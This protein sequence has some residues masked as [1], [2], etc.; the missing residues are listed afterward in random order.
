MSA[1]EPDQPQLFVR[2]GSSQEQRQ[3]QPLQE[4]YFAL[5]EM[6]F[7]DLL[8][9]AG[10][11]ARL[12]KFYQLDNT[13]DGDW[14]AYFSADETLVMA[15]ILSTRL[16]PLQAPFE[17]WWD[18]AAARSIEQLPMT[19]LARLLDGWI[20][21][22]AG[23]QGRAGR[24]LYALLADVIA[25]LCEDGHG[26]AALLPAPQLG[27]RA[28]WRRPPGASARPTLSGIKSNYYAFVKA[29]EMV[30]Q[31]AAR[32]LPGSL[33]SGEH[34][35]GAA[36]LIAFIRMA[37]RLNAR[38]NRF[39]GQHLDFYYDRILRAPALPAV[40]DHSYLV[41]APC[42]PGASVEIPAGT[43]FLAKPPGGGPE[44]VYLSDTR[45]LVGDASVQ[46]LHTLYFNRDRNVSPET[47]M[48]K[49]GSAPARHAWPSHAWIEHI[50]PPGKQV[51]TDP[52]LLRAVPLMG[53]P[54]N[55]AAAGQARHARLG[56]ALASNV[57]LMREGRRRLSL[58]L[59]FANQDLQWR[60]R[61]LESV[62]RH[63]KQQAG[64]TIDAVEQEDV[65]LRIL[66]S[67]FTMELTGPAGWI[68]LPAYHPSTPAAGGRH[69]AGYTLR[70]ECELAL[71]VPPVVAYTPALHG[72][73]FQVEVP[74]LRLLLNPDGYVYPYGLLRDLKLSAASIEV[75][76]SGCR[77]FSLNNQIGQLSPAA[78]FQPF[79]PVPV[80]GSYLIVGAGEAAGKELRHFHVDLEWG[81]LPADSGG[82]KTY[83]HDY[84]T[85][86]ET[87]DYVA[88]VAVLA[89]GV[90]R[91][92]EDQAPLAALFG[93]DYAR[94]ASRR[95]LKHSRL[96]CDAVLGHIRPGAALPA[97]GAAYSAASRNGY[98]KF[99]LAGPRFAFGHREYPQALA[100]A[101][102]RNLRG[103]GDNF[104][105]G[106]PE[107]PYTPLVA[108]ITTSYEAVAHIALQ[109]GGAAPDGGWNN[110][111]LHLH[112]QGWE[113]A[114]ASAAGGATLI[115]SYTELGYLHIGLSASELDTT[116]TLFFH[117][118]DDS[119][120]E[121]PAPVRWSYLRGNQWL[122]LPQRNI[123]SDS[124]DGFMSS[125][126]VALTIPADISLQHT[127]M[128]SG[129]YW[130]RISAAEG[131]R[132]FCSV[133]TVCTQAL[134]VRREAADMQ[135][136]SLLTLPAA[137][138]ER[139]RTPIPGLGKLT[140]VIATR[141]G[142][143]GENRAQRHT[144]LA[145]RLR[146]KGRAVTP[147]DYEALIL[148]QFPEVY[149]AKCFANLRMQ[150]QTPRDWVRPGN[151]LIV[152]VPPLPAGAAAHRMPQLNGKLVREVERYVTALAPPAA[153]IAVRHPVYEQIQVRCTVR[154]K[155][156]LAGGLYITRLN[157]DIS[158]FL[159]PWSAVGNRIHFGWSVRLH[160]VVSYI[161]GLD[162]IADVS[163]CSMLRIAPTDE[164]RYLLSDTAAEQSSA[165][166]WQ[167][168]WSVAVPVDKH[169]IAISDKEG[170]LHSADLQTLD[171][172]STFIISTKASDGTT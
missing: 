117:L 2:D 150:G 44:L 152:L 93:S 90:W 102:K 134:R 35:P 164:G 18:G 110:T 88:G 115:P 148:Q 73:D 43:A 145:E 168:P 135:S 111:L 119:L 91:P 1:P 162:Y 71:E 79:G 154:L 132:N 149:K 41:V 92:D 109:Q 60:L 75:G 10:E 42:A 13:P 21:D 33:V 165:I 157:E 108:A 139:S 70:L 52:A 51:T 40:G 89:D 31:E 124:T 167:Y 169:L 19:P 27:L 133:Y 26:F 30:Q 78:P 57:L 128:A 7:P 163:A 172:G 69:A 96:S 151:V 32:E 160:E 156:G 125:G 87:E 171:I 82:F 20:G 85:T 67:L 166:A 68:A 107:L 112:P 37:E 170:T 113:A 81:E 29:I 58:T 99:T 72:E 62:I 155:D 17:Q 159:S 158:R 105:A 63:K 146:H 123:I 22:L 38:L 137:S 24:K 14:Q 118:Q 101:M 45:L 114:N 4:G 5:A 9:M 53:A 100:H 39:T 127:V 136:T 86:V 11:Y 103:K 55:P 6:P 50:A 48:D 98:F 16:A 76:V 28:H 77:Q 97:N 56:F 147:A 120:P 49:G 64:D 153:A 130:L 12:V 122:P 138:I 34:E 25:S 104:M 3:L 36:L 66:G 141:G 74:M 95:V 144:R 106:V 140:Q 80:V 61:Q 126:V 15:R 83:Y 143:L 84:S 23:A 131:L 116:L 129:L 65:F 142:R 47:E 8:A 94:T 46:A 59:Q 161:I 121:Q 54:K